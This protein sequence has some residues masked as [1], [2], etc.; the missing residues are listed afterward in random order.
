MSIVLG[1][2]HVAGEVG[3]AFAQRRVGLLFGGV[4]VYREDKRVR[5]V[6]ETSV[7]PC[8]SAK[9]AAYIAHATLQQ[10]YPLLN[11]LVLQITIIFYFKQ[12]KCLFIYSSFRQF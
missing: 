2:A 6:S 4:L 1:R 8:Y 5:A 10:V 11:L 3:E 12:G 7:L 9:V